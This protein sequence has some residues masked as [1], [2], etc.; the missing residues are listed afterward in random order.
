MDTAVQAW[1]LSQLGTATPLADLTS[2]YTRLGTARKVALEVLNE[3]LANLRAQAATVNV[4]SVVSVSFTENIRAYERQIA[5][6]EADGSPAPD[7]TPTTGDDVTVLGTFQL[8]ERR[9]R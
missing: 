5:A 7:E 4:S 3:R 2:R 8:V 9:R 1:L 6:L